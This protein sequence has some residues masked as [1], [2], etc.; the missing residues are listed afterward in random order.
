MSLH[1][2]QFGDDCI[3]PARA[4][5]IEIPYCA[6]CEE[7]PSLYGCIHMREAELNLP[8]VVEASRPFPALRAKS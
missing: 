4:W 6:S 5:R 1:D 2:E 3:G 8:S 7:A